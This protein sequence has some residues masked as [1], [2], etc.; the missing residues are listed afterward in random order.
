MPIKHIKLTDF[1]LY[2]SK[3]SNHAI[4]NGIMIFLANFT[5]KIFSTLY[6]NDCIF[7]RRRSFSKGVELVLLNWSSKLS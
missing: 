6:E 2:I 7:W 4:G 3:L 1:L 5:L